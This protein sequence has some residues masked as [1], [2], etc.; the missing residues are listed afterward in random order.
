MTGSPIC[1]D[2]K[3]VLMAR[4]PRDILVSAYYSIAYSH[5]EPTST[6]SKHADFME[7]RRRARESNG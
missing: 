7:M 5:P 1:P 3:V 6:G 2:Y 4:D